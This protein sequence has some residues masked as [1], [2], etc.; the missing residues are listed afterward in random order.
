MDKE[1]ALKLVKPHLSQKRYQHTKR[2]LTTALELAQRYD[3]DEEE[4]MLAAVF[5]DYAKY[6][7]LDEMSHIIKQNELPIDLLSFHH[8]LWHGPV[9]SILVETEIGIT[10]Q[11]VKDAIY[12][13]TTGRGNMSE[14]EKVVY[15]ADYIEPGRSFPGL[16]L[17]QKKAKEDLDEACFMA[18]RNT[19]QFLLE[20][21][22]L[23]Y[24]ETINMYNHLKR[25][26]EESNL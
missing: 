14:L 6:R 21:E 20:R 23:I 7:P 13:H 19:I 8:E 22:R 2:V 1:Q 25:I 24:P 26:L 17:I 4:T 10:N 12:W 3:V 5:H 15:L 9:A 18:V 11:Q 16:S